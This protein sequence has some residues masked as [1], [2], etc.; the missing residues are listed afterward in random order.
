MCNM[1]CFHCCKPDCDNDRIQTA[2]ERKAQTEVDR[3]ILYDRK[4]GREKTVARYRK[5]EKYK[6]HKKMYQSSDKGKEVIKKYESSEKAK[7]RYRR[8]TNSE[9]GKAVRKQ[10]REQLIKTGKN[11]EYCRAY[12]QRQKEKKLALVGGAT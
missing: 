10:Y 2:A 7:E 6:A 11:A 5:S 12:Y 3:E 9:R 4:E 8:Y 1:D